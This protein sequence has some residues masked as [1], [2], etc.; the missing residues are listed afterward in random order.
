MLRWIMK[1]FRGRTPDETSCLCIWC[2]NWAP[3]R[4]WIETRGDQGFSNLECPICGA[5]SFWDLDAPVPLLLHRV[6]ILPDT[7]ATP[8]SAG[9]ADEPATKED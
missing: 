7:P 4:S 5:V 9:P 6:A 8:P 3:L 2:D 1:M